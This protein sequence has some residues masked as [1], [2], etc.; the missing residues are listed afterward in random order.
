MKT[1][2]WALLLTVLIGSGFD[3]SAA[4]GYILGAVIAFFILVYL[5]YSLVKPE[6]F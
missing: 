5:I 6:K 1:T 4:S 3:K 2:V